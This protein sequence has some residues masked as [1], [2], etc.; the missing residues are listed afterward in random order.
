MP[1]QIIV[2]QCEKVNDNTIQFVWSTFAPHCL[3]GETIF[4]RLIKDINIESLYKNNSI[5]FDNRKVKTFL[6]DWMDKNDD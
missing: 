1:C 4:N 5:E 6:L 2:R 3:C